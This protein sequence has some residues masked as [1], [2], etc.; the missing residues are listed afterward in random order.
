MYQVY[1]NV[2][3]YFWSVGA[4]C[5][6]PFFGVVGERWGGVV[7]GWAAG[8]RRDGGAEGRDALQNPVAS[9]RV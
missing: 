8:G 7:G 6:L 2:S 4:G 1:R 3:I 5:Y 9:W